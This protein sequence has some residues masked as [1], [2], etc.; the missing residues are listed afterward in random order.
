MV[1][2]LQWVKVFAHLLTA[3]N[4][5]VIAIALIVFLNRHDI[6]HRTL[7]RLSIIF[8]T[9]VS[10]DA[11]FAAWNQYH[12]HSGTLAMMRFGTAVFGTAC[13]VYFVVANR[14][15]IQTLR[16]SELWSSAQK[17]RITDSEQVRLN[18]AYASEQT[19]RKSQEMVMARYDKTPRGE[20]GR[21]TLGN[22]HYRLSA[23]RSSFSH[24]SPHSSA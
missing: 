15:I 11:V 17:D 3:I 6:G 18:M 24:G 23:H 1:N 14:D 20:N 12:R 22:D 7:I 21:S 5:A 13:V 10:G 16:I 2:T 8:N 4:F 19:L 9:M